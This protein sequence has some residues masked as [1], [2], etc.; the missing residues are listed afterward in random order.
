MRI[1]YRD[2]C[3]DKLI[4]VAKEMA[5]AARTA[6]KGRGRDQ[7]HIF[8]LTDDD[9]DALAKQ[10]NRIGEEEDIDFF[11]RDARNLSS[12]PVILLLGTEC[13]PLEVRHCGFCGL[14]DCKENR[15]SG[16]AHCTFSVGDLGIA[17]GSA[18]AY[19]ARRHIDNRIMFTAGKAAIELGCFPEPVKVAYGI[20]L[21]ATGKNP[22]FDRK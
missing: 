15:E 19:A 1:E 10:M 14:A 21:S 4:D 8:I 9:K 20:P 22:F 3:K 18:A 6:P 11:V 17:V 12:V 5:L 16:T 13:S 7:L 2:Y